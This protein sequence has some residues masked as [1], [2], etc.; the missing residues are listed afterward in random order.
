MEYISKN[1]LGLMLVI[2][3]FLRQVLKFVPIRFLTRGAKPPL[4]YR[5][6]L[7]SAILIRMMELH[8]T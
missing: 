5:H 8:L 6:N 7:I 2:G 4:L 1:N 3:S